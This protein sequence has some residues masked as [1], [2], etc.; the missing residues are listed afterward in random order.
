MTQPERDKA[1]FQL[2]DRF[3][4]GIKIQ[5]V[6]PELIQRYLSPSAKGQRPETLNGVFQRL[7]ESAQ[8]ANMKAGVVGGSIGGVKNLSSVLS[9]FD[10][11]KVVEEYG[12]DWASLL[13]AIQT[14]LKPRG[15]MR[16]TS[17]SIW[18]RYCRSVLS[19]ASF[20]SQFASA[21]DFYDWIA[22]FDSDDKLR[23]AL[24]MLLD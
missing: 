3:L 17:R 4:H 19:S 15:K 10:F 22:N 21:K 8:N 6:T 5:G 2:A 24:P 18:P 16:M 9:G 12:E 7:L 23:P 14:K 1:A 20:L 11:K 13:E